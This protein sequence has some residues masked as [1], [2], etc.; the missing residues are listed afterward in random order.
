MACRLIAGGKGKTMR[1]GHFVKQPQGYLAFIPA[2]LPPAPPLNMLKLTKLLSEADIALGRLDGSTSTL[3]NPELFVAMYVR[4]EAVLSSQIEGTQASLADLLEAEAETDEM[5]EAPDIEE[6]VNY[7]RAINYGLE[8][9]KTL[10]LSLRLICEI[11]EILL[12][13]VRGED[14]Q[15][16]EFRRRQ[17]WI[18]PNMGP[19]SI[20]TATFIPPPPG[21]ELMDALS[22]L[23]QF[24]HDDELP[25]L[26]HAALCHAQ[27]ETIHPFSDGNGRIGRLLITFLLC[28]RGVL[29]RPLLYLSLFL[30]LNRRE[31]YDRL[32]DVRTKGA[33]EE[34]IEFFL[35][36][37]RQVATEANQ[38]AMDILALRQT[39]REILSNEGR[40]SGNLLRTLDVLF[41]TPLI[42]PK[43]LA[44]KLETTYPTANTIMNRMTELGIVTE[45]TG[46]KRNRRFSYLP[47]IRLFA[48]AESRNV[49]EE[50]TEGAVAMERT[51]SSS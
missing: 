19:L 25:S 6:V 47:Y 37:V 11:H 36:G 50:T 4:R 7:V 18:G 39:H 49:A 16:G 45:R 8:R 32:Q 2:K 48:E 22:D 41:E 12:Q 38:T 17:V 24:M 40:A 42:T 29:S 44:R 9:L 33:W 43:L 28:N 14:K 3:P 15:P 30:K 13:G 35:R 20:N 31:Y 21:G 34:W 51:M 1:A 10:P 46:F 5:R 27:F 23:E 26:I